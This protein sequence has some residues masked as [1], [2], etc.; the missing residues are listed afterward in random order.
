MQPVEAPSMDARLRARRIE[1]LRS[2]GRKRLR[3]L[4]VAL[5]LTV[6][7]VAAWGLTRSPLL[8]VDEFVISGATSTAEADIISASG[9]SLGD[10]LTDVNLEQ[11]TQG[12]AALPWVQNA[13]VE[14]SWSGKILVNVN[15]RVPAAIVEDGRSQTWLI[16]ASGQVLGLVS[17]YKSPTNATNAVELAALTTISGIESPTLGEKLESVPD[18]LI[19]LVTAVP[20]DLAAMVHRVYLDAA[21]EI[22]F[23]LVGESN[24]APPDNPSTEE[25]ET[26]VAGRIRFGDARNPHEQLRSASLVVAQVDLVDLDVIDVRVPSDPVVTRIDSSMAGSSGEQD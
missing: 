10:A 18:Q 9:I 24:D 15:E 23:E 4:V 8:D 7:L 22:W 1:V 11:A 12:V 25:S 2:Q 3:R 26:A 5:A 16:D 21:G 6:L 17:D 14:R 19:S 13:Q 20:D